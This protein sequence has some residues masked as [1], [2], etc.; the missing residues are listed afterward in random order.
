MS[1][2]FV[3]MQI[4]R[5]DSFL[6]ATVVLVDFVAVNRIGGQ[7]MIQKECAVRVQIEEGSPKK[8]VDLQNVPIGEVALVIGPYRSQ[9]D[10][11]T[12]EWI[13]EPEAIKLARGN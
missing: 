2:Q 9:A 6:V 11:S 3:E 1:E 12:I 13:D 10:S 5:V 8:T 7:V 4:L